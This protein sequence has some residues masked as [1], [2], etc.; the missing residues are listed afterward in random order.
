M[1]KATGQKKTKIVKSFRDS[2]GKYSTIDAH[3]NGKG[4]T[5]TGGK[6]SETV[7]IVGGKGA[8]CLA[9]YEAGEGGYF[10]GGKGNDTFAYGGGALEITDYGTGADKISLSNGLSM[11]DLTDFTVTAAEGDT[12]GKI[13]LS[14]G[15][16]DKISIDVADTS[17]AITF[18]EGK[19]STAYTFKEVDDVKIVASGKN[20]IVVTGGKEVDLSTLTTYTTVT[21]VA[22]STLNGGEV[23]K[24]NLKLTGAAETSLVGGSKNDTLI[25]AVGESGTL[26]GNGGKDVFIYQ[27]GSVTI[28]D[29]DG[30]SDKISVSADVGS[31][32]D[33]N[34]V[35][36]NGGYELV[37]TD[38]KSVT[39]TLTVNFGDS[40]KPVNK[41]KIALTTTGSNNKSTTTTFFASDGAIFDKA[42]AAEETLTSAAKKVTLFSGDADSDFSGLL[43]TNSDKT[44]TVENGGKGVTSK[45]KAL[46]TV[47]ANFDDAEV[48]GNDKANTITLDKGGEATGGLG[49]DTYIIGGDATINDFGIGAKTY[50]DEDTA[51]ITKFATKVTDTLY[52][53]NDS[54]TYAEGSDI[55]KINGVVTGVT[56]SSDISGDTVKPS[57]ANAASYSYAESFSVTL[58]VGT[59]DTYEIVLDNIARN[60]KTVGSSASSIVVNT[61]SDWKDLSKV[62]IYDTSGKNGAFKQIKWT[63]NKTTGAVSLGSVAVDLLSSNNFITGDASLSELTKDTS[64]NV[65][66]DYSAGSESS[67]L[68]KTTTTTSY[69]G[70]TSS[71]KNKN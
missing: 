36:A 12:K 53:P 14:F 16:S 1:K 63:R 43:L 7:T 25:A 67:D 40:V 58:S 24:K 55:V 69:T 59:S 52:D 2:L 62:R 13:E 11:S 38:D 37:F 49:N 21:G 56:V 32:T 33:V 42:P 50:Y 20:A 45:Y 28:E 46:K 15:N 29:Y 6:S 60:A 64:S 8:D 34:T 18:M 3:A 26:K 10:T 35:T 47:T 57:K 22:S 70:G 44:V 39:N 27:G 17:K 9:I 30:G 54:S 65:I 71:N 31:L 66:G 19:T 51:K 4:L 5:L 48:V 41:N 23:T 68:G 61:N